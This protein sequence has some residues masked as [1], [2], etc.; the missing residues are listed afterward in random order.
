MSAAED[1]LEQL[2]YAKMG[3]VDDLHADMTAAREIIEIVRATPRPMPVPT[4]PSLE[5]EKRATYELSEAAKANE[6]RRLVPWIALGATSGLR[7]AAMYYAAHELDRLGA[8]ASAQLA[9]DIAA[10]IAKED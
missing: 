2:V 9:R 4:A 3:L 8:P 6:R 5:D 7:A 1:T 10:T